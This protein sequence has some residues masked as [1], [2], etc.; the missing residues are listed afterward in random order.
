MDVYVDGY[1]L[2]RNTDYT[3]TSTSSITT[4]FSIPVG[5]MIEF[6]IER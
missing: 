2:V 3:E 1:K 5:S 6:R 4:T